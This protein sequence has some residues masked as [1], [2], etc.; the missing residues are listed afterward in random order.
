V[1]LR[2]IVETVIGLFALLGIA[3]YLWL[4]SHRVGY[5]LELDFIEGVMMDHMARIAHGQPIYVAPTLH[6]IP[7]AYMPFFTVVGGF[8]MR[9]TGPTF[10]AARVVSFGSTLITMAL[11]A[12]IVWRETRRRSL[13]LAAAGIYAMAFGITGACYD[14]ARPDSL[15]LMLSFSGLAVLRFSK[16]IPGALVAALL[17]TLGFFSKQHSILFTFGALAYLFFH[18]RRRFLPFALAMVAGCGGGYLLLD[19]WLGDWFRIFTWSIPRGWSTLNRARIEHYVAGGLLGSFACSTVPALMSL[20]VR[21]AEPEPRRALWYWTGLAAVG[22]GL[23]AT[24]DPWAYLHVFTPTVVALSILGP[25]ALDRL[26]RRLDAAEGVREGFSTTIALIVVAA[27]FLP[28]LYS[29]GL[30]RPRPHARE[31]HDALISRLRALPGGVMLPYH[32]WYAAQS[33]ASGS[34]QYIALNDIERSRGNELLKRD[35]QYLVRMFQPL[36]SGPGRPAIVTDVPLE[37]TGPLWQRVAA[38]YQVVDSLGPLTATL[39][40]LTGNQN[41][42]TYVYL[43]VGPA[44]ADS[45]K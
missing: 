24:L 44:A 36:L 41:S 38:G 7:L 23:L 1:I 31:A 5:P 28:L 20:G 27:Q 21:D 33:G 29:V 19:L 26:A 11:L 12:G 6:F 14:V 25:L 3:S 17:L 42:L 34:L 13:A 35:P 4:G 2:R 45:A 39:R 22:T 10:F 15:M 16:G 32:G 43:P 37:H 9:F 18:E 30:H 40:P 8:V